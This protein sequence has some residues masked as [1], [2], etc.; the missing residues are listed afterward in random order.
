MKNDGFYS[1]NF[2][3]FFIL[4]TLSSICNDEAKSLSE[5]RHDILVSD[6]VIS[7]MRMLCNKNALKINEATP[8]RSFMP[9]P[10]N[11]NLQFSEFTFV[12]IPEKSLP[13]RPTADKTHEIS[14]SFAENETSER[15]RH[16]GKKQIISTFTPFSAIKSKSF[17][18]PSSG[19]FLTVTNVIPVSALTDVIISLTSFIKITVLILFVN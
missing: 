4:K 3:I 7:L 6:A 8:L 15:P 16:D 18:T 14:P 1:V 13:S 11:V 19:I 5:I 9:S 17:E 2:Y 10:E 12:Y